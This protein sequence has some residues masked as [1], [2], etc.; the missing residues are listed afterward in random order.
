MLRLPRRG[1]D[2]AIMSGSEEVEPVVEVLPAAARAVTFGTR[3]IRFL[4][5]S[6]TFVLPVSDAYNFGFPCALISCR[7]TRW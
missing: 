1:T 7:K 6:F 2:R 5:G 3:L 4:S